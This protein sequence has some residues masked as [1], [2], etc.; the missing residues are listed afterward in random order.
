M[1]HRLHRRYPELGPPRLEGV[2]TVYEFDD[3]YTARRNG[4]ASADDYY[5]RCSLLTALERIAVPGLIVHAMDDPFIPHEPF[6]QVVRPPNL[7]LDLLRHGG[8]LGYLSRRPWQGDRRWLDARLDDWLGGHWG[9]SGPRDIQ[10][11]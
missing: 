7:A 11:P 1:I 2:K 8:H 10:L 4:F 6:G 3:R 9:I 5:T